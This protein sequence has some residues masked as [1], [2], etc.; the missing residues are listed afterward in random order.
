MKY[1]TMKRLCALLFA[2]VL[3]LVLWLIKKGVDNSLFR[4]IAERDKR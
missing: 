4:Y 1:R 2:L 3:L